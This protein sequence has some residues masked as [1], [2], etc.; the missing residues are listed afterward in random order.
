MC[1]THLVDNNSFHLFLLNDC[2]MLYLF[3]IKCSRYLTKR[4][5]CYKNS[6][7][8]DKLWL[9]FFP[10][11]QNQPKSNF[12]QSCHIEK[13]LAIRLNFFIS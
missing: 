12:L 5:L 8:M 13:N 1:E 6:L 2:R 10:H 4:L 9:H 3:K 11:C 7:K